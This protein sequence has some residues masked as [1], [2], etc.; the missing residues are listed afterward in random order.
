MVGFYLAWRFFCFFGIFSVA[1]AL[2]KDVTKEKNMLQSEVVA[3]VMVIETFE[4][5]AVL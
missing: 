3:S 1:S 5:L 4:Y 2:S